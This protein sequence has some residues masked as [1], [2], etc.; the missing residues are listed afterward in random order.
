MIVLIAALVAWR[1][2]SEARRARLEQARPQV[3][4][5]LDTPK[6]GGAIEIVLANIG[7]TMARNVS[8]TFTPA[9]QSTFDGTVGADPP[10]RIADLSIWND[11]PTLAPGQEFRTTFDT[12]RRRFDSQLPDRFTARV[13]YGGIGAPRNGYIEEQVIDVGIIRQVLHTDQRDLHD[14]VKSIQGIEKTVDKLA[15]M[16]DRK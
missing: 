5:R 9:L 1:Q 3:T 11:L 8:V 14:L 15:R 4:V 2:L 16:A 12:P 13:I 7:R 6:P 10:W